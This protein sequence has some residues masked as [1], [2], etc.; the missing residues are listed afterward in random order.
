MRFVATGHVENIVQIWDVATGSLVDR[1]RGHTDSVYSVTFTPD[2]KGLVSGAL[3]QKVKYWELNTAIPRARKVGER[4]GKHVLDYSGN[5]DYVLSIAISQD[6]QWVASGSRDHR[7]QF[8]DK[9]G[10][11]QLTLS[12]HKKAGM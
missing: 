9:H 5:Q 8:W 12:G 7:V 1:L 10:R 11:A 6:G 3:D 4:L 2:S